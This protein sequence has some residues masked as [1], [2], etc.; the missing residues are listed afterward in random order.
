[1]T[2]MKNFDIS[3]KDQSI[4]IY[5]WTTIR[6]PTYGKKTC[7]ASIILSSEDAVTLA[8]YMAEMQERISKLEETIEELNDDE[9][10]EEDE[11][12]YEWVSMEER[13]EKMKEFNGI[14]SQ[15]A[16]TLRHGLPK[17]GHPT[18]TKPKQVAGK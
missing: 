18:E 17:P 15:I 9:E 2:E 13:L 16:E 14:R 12:P 4:T 3:S 6:I 10:Y 5:D 7:L 8:R 1:M 11:E